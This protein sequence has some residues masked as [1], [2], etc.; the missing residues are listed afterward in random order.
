MGANA[1]RRAACAL[2]DDMGRR[3]ADPAL[4]AAFETDAVVAAV[5]NR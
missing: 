3:I 4:R 1:D 2:L 5:K